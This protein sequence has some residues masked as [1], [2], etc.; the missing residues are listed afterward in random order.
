MGVIED[1]KG[2]KILIWG[3]GREGQSTRQFLKRILPED[4]YVI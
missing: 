4:N 2:K 1:L 3:Y